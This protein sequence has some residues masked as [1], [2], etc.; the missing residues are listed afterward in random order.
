M[1]TMMLQLGEKVAC[2]E[3]LR[4]QSFVGLG[5]WPS[6]TVVT[7]CGHACLTC[8]TGCQATALVSISVHC[9]HKRYCMEHVRFCTML[10]A[11]C[12]SSMAAWQ[13]FPA[14]ASEW[15]ILARGV[16]SS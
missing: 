3:L 12:S 16:Q 4:M 2:T 14:I 1:Q 8:C 13:S 6:S 11:A 5:C 15:H 10:H 7:E 9:L